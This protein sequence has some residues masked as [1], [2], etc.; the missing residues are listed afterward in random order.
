M[1]PAS[2]FDDV[3]NTGDDAFSTKKDNLNN[4][5]NLNVVIALLEVASDYCTEVAT[6]H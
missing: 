6:S 4:L 5:I 1:T 2:Y 3:L